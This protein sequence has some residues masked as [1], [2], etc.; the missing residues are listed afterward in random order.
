M[1][2]RPLL[3]GK[4]GNRLPGNRLANLF[5]RPTFSHIS[6]PGDEDTGKGKRAP[7]PVRVAY[8]RR[9]RTLTRPMAV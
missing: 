5:P 1:A 4:T 7:N 6:Y 2:N 3:A 9:R 8:R